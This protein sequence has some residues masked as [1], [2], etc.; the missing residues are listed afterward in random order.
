MRGGA[1]PQ[2]GRSWLHWHRNRQHSPLVHQVVA[3][4]RVKLPPHPTT[5]PLVQQGPRPCNSR[6]LLN[7]SSSTQGMPQTDRGTPRIDRGRRRTERGTPRTDRGTPRG[8]WGTPRSN[9][10]TYRADRGTP[11]STRGT[12]RTHRG[13]PRTARADPGLTGSRPGATGARLGLTGARPGVTRAHAVP[14]GQPWRRR[15]RP[16]PAGRDSNRRP[17]ILQSAVLPIDRCLF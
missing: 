5:K 12:P 1:E 13:T 14:L 8:N 10:G 6:A 11:R 9:R 15:V 7:I 16:P 2:C 3:G 4:W 17:K